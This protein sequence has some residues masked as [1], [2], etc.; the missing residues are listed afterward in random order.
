MNK[1]KNTISIKNIF[2]KLVSISLLLF[3]LLI[4]TGCNS[5]KKSIN[6]YYPLLDDKIGEFVSREIEVN[7]NNK[8]VLL[9]SVKDALLDSEGLLPE[10]A[11]NPYNSLV[12]IS[13]VTLDNKVLVVNFDGDY[14]ALSLSERL[15][16]RAGI[17]K[18][19]SS[20]TFIEKIRF[21]QKGKELKDE[22]G[23]I[24]EDTYLENVITSIK[25]S[26]ESSNIANYN[27]YFGSADGKRLSREERTLEVQT[28]YIL[29]KE[30]VDELI[31]GPTV[32]G[33]NQTVPK[34]TKIRQLEIKDNI[35]YVDL[36]KEFA[37]K[38]PGGF[39]GE[40]LTIY[41]LVNTL[42]E[43]PDIEKVQFLIEGEKI[44]KYQGYYDF[45]NPFTRDS[46]LIYERNNEKQELNNP[47]NI[48]KILKEGE[49][50]DPNEDLALIA[51]QNNKDSKDNK[52]NKDNNSDEPLE[53][54]IKKDKT[55]KE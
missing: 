41:S 34:Q 16:I 7:S 25:D 50:Y 21:L 40:T 49:E 19:Y 2:N 54:L 55:V 33:L 8:I 27:L 53:E 48:V 28:N 44:E 45:S 15:A 47:D 10:D 23:N 4:F 14:Y 32:D 43:L 39:D 51:K 37:T 20:F 30:L 12:K 11:K 13:Y 3:T 18:S 26:F 9:D 31:K 36:S 1:T 42:T 5:D 46:T 24:L 35:C 38:H 6:I 22:Y 17:A 52:D 29:A